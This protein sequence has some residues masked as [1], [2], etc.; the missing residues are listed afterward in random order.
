[1][2]SLLVHMIA[3]GLYENTVQAVLTPRPGCSAISKHQ[4]R[5]T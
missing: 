4:T 3:V 1:M 5:P 2:F